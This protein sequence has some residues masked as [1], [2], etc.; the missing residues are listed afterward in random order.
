MKFTLNLLMLVC[1]VTL[2]IGCAQ[3]LAP[4]LPDGTPATQPTTQ[5]LTDSPATAIGNGMIVVS[6]AA[7]A[8]WNALIAAIG[9]ALGI[10]SAVYAKH[11]SASAKTN[12]CQAMDAADSV[13]QALSLGVKK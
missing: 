11:H 13:V 12:A 4:R 8:P 10:A 6:A 3:M 5:P 9:S 7:P 1:T 2:M